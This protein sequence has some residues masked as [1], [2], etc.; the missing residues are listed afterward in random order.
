MENSFLQHLIP[1]ELEAPKSQDFGSQAAGLLLELDLAESV[2]PRDLPP[3]D[4]I[5]EARPPIPAPSSP[6]PKN[7]ENLLRLSDLESELAELKN[8]ASQDSEKIADRLGELELRFQ[9][10]DAQLTKLQTKLDQPRP[11][12]RTSMASALLIPLLGVGLN[13][14]FH[15]GLYKLFLI[16]GQPGY[17]W[18]HLAAETLLGLQIATE[19]SPHAYFYWMTVEMVWTS[20]IIVLSL[21]ILLRRLRRKARV[22]ARSMERAS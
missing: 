10:M 1:L 5:A 3:A 21:S 15:F 20:L 8:E 18:V 22:A 7:G 11:F 19:A 4:P 2:N 16:A 9:Q 13:A 6:V 14:L 17:E 12:I